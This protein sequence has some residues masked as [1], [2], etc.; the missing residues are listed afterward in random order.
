MQTLIKRIFG[1]PRHSDAA[2]VLASKATQQVS[3]VWGRADS[4]QRSMPDP[5]L[6]L[7]D[8]V[9]TETLLSV[10]RRAY[11]EVET[12]PSGSLR[13]GVE[14]AGHVTVRIDA[15][16]RLLAFIQHYGLKEEVTRSVKLEFANRIN[17]L[18]VLVRM[19][20]ADET[21]LVSDHYMAYDGVVTARQIVEG[22]RRFAHVT[23]AAVMRM[24]T[25]DVM[26]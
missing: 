14:G 16:R 11:M 12:S 15:E 6:L 26:Q 20:V 10:F 8:Q 19:T 24:D 5:E 21:T 23:H 1:H 2:A 17:D 9:T 3:T 13:V 18:A 25:D 7:P 4:V 22:L